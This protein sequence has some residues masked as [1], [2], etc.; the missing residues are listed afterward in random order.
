MQEIEEIQKN[1]RR[2]DGLS[3]HR[4]GE[5]KSET[6]N[7]SYEASGRNLSSHRIVERKSESENRSYEA[8]GRNH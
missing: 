6:E 5:R 3:R 2:T 7:R 8:S 4:V 1:E